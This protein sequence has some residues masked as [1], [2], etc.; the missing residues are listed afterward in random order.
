MCDAAEKKHVVLYHTV[1]SRK[2]NYLAGRS[3]PRLVSETHYV[4]AYNID[5]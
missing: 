3:S 1:Q 4:R 5:V 2:S